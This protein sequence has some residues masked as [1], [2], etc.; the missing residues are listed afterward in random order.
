VAGRDAAL[1]W[2]ALVSKLNGDR[3]KT[4]FDRDIVVGDGF[5]LNLLAVM[6]KVCAP[7]ALPTSPKLEKIDPTYVLSE[8]RVNYSD[9]TRLGVAAGSLERVESESSPGPHAAYRHVI[10]LEP[11]DLVDENQIPLPRTPNAEEV[12]KVSSKFGFITEAFYLTGSLLELGYSSTYSLYGDTLMR[13]NELKK[14]MD[15]VE[16]M[17][18]GVSTF[19]GFREVMLKKLEKERLEEVRRKLCYDVYLMGTDQFGPDLICFAASSSSYLLRLLCF[20]NPPELPLSVPPGMKAAVQLEAMVDDVV[21]IMINS[22]RYDP[23]AVDRSAPMIDNILT[24]SV[25]AINSPLHF[26]NPYLRSRLA[27]LLW[28]MAPRTSERDGM[29]RNT[30]WQA[31]FEAHPFLK[32]HLMRAIFRLYVDVET[33][34]SSSQFYD[35]FSSRYYLSDIL[36]ELWD[37]QH[38]RRSLHE[39]VAAN[40]KLVLNTINMLLNDANWLLDDTIDTLQELHGLQMIMG[41]PADWNSLTQEQQ[42]EKRERFAELEKKL[43]RTLRLANSSVQVLVALT[44]DENIRKVFL[45]PEVVERVAVMLNYYLKQ[46]VGPRCQELKL[47][48]KEDYGWEPKNLLTDI[49][50]AYLNLAKSDKFAAAIAIDH[51]SY[52]ESIF[53]SAIDKAT[54]IRFLRPPEIQE[55]RLLLQEIQKTEEIEEKEAELFADAPDEFLDPIMSTLMQDPVTLPASGM[56]C[57]RPVIERHLLSDP[58]DPFNRKPLKAEHLIPNV[59]LRARIREYMNLKKAGAR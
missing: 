15:R 44:G 59:E 10:S 30:A 7:F 5:I 56:V 48:N 1:E 28:L 17:G 45:R 49:M 12:I 53:L 33:T 13:I 58:S 41:N 54:R 57:D 19:P 24:L 35:K 42:K 21:N 8:A 23:D 18:A 51:R 50:R 27:E 43:K 2:L 25:V 6:L 22:L 40:E 32:K 29:R 47:K 37:D 14:Q 46:L 26:K 4:Y 55:F 34:G 39:L 9:A 16:S 31:A 52:S 38:Y 11:T 36:M 20:G 3:R